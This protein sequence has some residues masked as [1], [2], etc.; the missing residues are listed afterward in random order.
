MRNLRFT[1][2]YV[3]A[4]QQPWFSATTR[5]FARVR[6]LPHTIA[7]HTEFE[8]TGV[9]DSSAGF[10]CAPGGPG[11]LR[12][13][14]RCPGRMAVRCEAGPSVAALHNREARWQTISLQLATSTYARPG[15]THRRDC[16]NARPAGAPRS[17]VLAQRPQATAP[18]RLC[19]PEGAWEELVPPDSLLCSDPQLR[20][21]ERH[22]RMRLYAF[23]HF[24]H[25]E[26]V[27]RRLP[28]RTCSPTKAG[29][30]SRA[31]STP[32]SIA[33][34]TAGMALCGSMPTWPSSTSPGCTSTGRP[35]PRARAS[36][37]D[38]RWCA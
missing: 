9:T 38:L 28:F 5:V 29:A 22:L 6:L 23:D 34:P 7:S 3:Q 25:D 17:L 8:F 4:L 18:C 21:W 32:T 30:W 20:Q 37:L 15:R 2:S 33:A 12:H 36:S 27:D 24:R 1:Q 11:G 31:R 16:R 10:S 35:Q 14:T 13:L 19:S 26:V